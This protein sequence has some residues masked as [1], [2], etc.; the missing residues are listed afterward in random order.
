MS[1]FFKN[2]KK[3]G[4]TGPVWGL[5]PVKGGRDKKRVKEGEY[6]GNIMYSRM[7]IEK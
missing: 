6:D 1:F 4:K 2:R 7:K 5:V 3:K